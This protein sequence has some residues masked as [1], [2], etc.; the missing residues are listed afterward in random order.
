MNFLVYGDAERAVARRDAL[1]ALSDRIGALASPGP[2]I[3]IGIGRHAALVAALIEAGELAQGLADAAARERG[4]DEVSCTEQ[5]AMRLVRALAAAVGQSWESGFG[6]AKVA[7]LAPPLKALESV[8]GPDALLLR[9]P[10]G[11][12]FYALYPEG[13]F[14]AARPLRDAGPWRVVG[15]RSIGTSLA[16]MTA[17]G[18]AAPPPATVRPVGHPFARRIEAGRKLEDRLVGGAGDR[19]ALVD[20][21]PGLSGSSFGALADFLEARGVERGRLHVFPGHGGDLGGRASAAHRARWAEVPRHV[22]GFDA[23]F[24]RDGDPRHLAG[25]STPLV[26]A[27]DGTLRDI[28]GGAWRREMYPDED[29]WPAADGRNERRKFLLPAGGRTWLL[30]FASLGRTG[31]HKLAMASALAAA[32]YCPP[33][34]GLA[35]GFLVEEWLAGARPLDPG[36]IAAGHDRRARFLDRLAAY[37]AFRTNRLLPLRAG[38]PLP[39]LFAMARFNAGEALGEAAAAAVERWRAELPRIAQVSHP[40]AIDGRL[41]PHE[42]LETA[43][44]RLLKTDAL[45]HGAAHDLVGGQDIAWDIAGAGAEFALT[46]AE[47]EN[48]RDQVELRADRPVSPRLVAF[49]RVA[50]CAF[51]LGRSA[52]AAAALGGEC[53]ETGRLRAEERRYSRALHGILF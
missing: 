20:E 53:A 26:G 36:R 17:A 6:D 25:W 51:H 45:D 13:H 41:H 21:G 28:S 22:A 44:G 52:L 47:T 16:A 7:G 31:E 12:A 50:Y 4:R 34:A 29:R 18:L 38:A 14:A 24:L 1:A 9:Q 3:G 49:M 48:L 35:H 32:G 37:L 40:V 11:Y 10:E 43:D 2:G 8:G 5:A 33:V 39:E 27:A 46:P 42:W 19:I 23:L 30:K 15:I